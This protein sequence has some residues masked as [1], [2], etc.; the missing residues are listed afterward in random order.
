MILL[1]MR[2]GN[3]HEI[4]LLE[5]L[6]AFNQILNGSPAATEL[7]VSVKV[8]VAASPRACGARQSERNTNIKV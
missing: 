1:S 3:I 8:S 5:A 2:G 4:S 7:V 6:S